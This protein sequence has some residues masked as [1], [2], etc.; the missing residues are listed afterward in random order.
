MDHCRRACMSAARSHTRGCFIRAPE[1]GKI[2][3]HNT[4]L[5]AFTS[6][7][8]ESSRAHNSHIL[9][10]ESIHTYVRT[11]RQKFQMGSRALAS[12]LAFFQ[13]TLYVDGRAPHQVG[14]KACT[15]C[16]SVCY[17]NKTKAHFPPP[18]QSSDLFLFSLC[19]AF[20]VSSGAQ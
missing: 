12:Q 5:A 2:I 20:Y 15:I 1:L 10:T 6:I 16:H 4:R 18:P 8:P 9:H 13:E 19:F 3:T 14:F 11:Q 17:K 7:C